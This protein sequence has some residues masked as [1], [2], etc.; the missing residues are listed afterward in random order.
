M[1]CDLINISDYNADKFTAEYAMFPVVTDHEPVYLCEEDWKFLENGYSL[2]GYG[3]FDYGF[4]NGYESPILGQIG[5][6]LPKNKRVS[7]P[8]VWKTRCKLPSRS[9]HSKVFKKKRNVCLFF[10]KRFKRRNFENH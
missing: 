9:S 2:T 8:H 10:F 4:L 3:V 7:E 5:P 6:P 1:D